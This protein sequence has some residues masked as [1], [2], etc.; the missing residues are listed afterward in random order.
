MRGRIDT[1]AELAASD[2]A[3]PRDGKQTVFPGIGADRFERFVARA[4]QMAT[5]GA[6]YL[7]APLDL[8]TSRREI[9][10]DIEVDSMRDRCYLHGF[11][12]RRDGSEASERFI[13]FL[14]E[15]GDDA[16]ERQAFA[17]A[18]AFLQQGEPFVAYVYSTYERT[19]YRKLQAR[20]PDVCSDAAVEALFDPARVVDLYAVAR[21]R[22][23]WPTRN[24]SLKTLASHLGFR[25]RDAH[26]S[27]AESI[28][29]FHRWSETRSPELRQRILEYNE[30]DCRAT[31]VLLD[32]M[33]S[34]PE[35]PVEV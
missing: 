20:Y 26:P 21:N 9:F 19:W 31:R 7:T 8:P 5:G 11:L 10:F 12:E 33:R 34:L 4:R 2:A 23:V 18:W 25:W 16:S 30:D 15:T 17:D 35:G 28:E 24:D 6:P 13:S 32:G 3:A 1:V 22:T 14:A 27:G 29:W